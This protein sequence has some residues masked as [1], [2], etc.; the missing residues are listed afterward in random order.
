MP[1]ILAVIYNDACGLEKAAAVKNSGGKKQCVPK[2]AFSLN[3]AKESF[4]F[5]TVTDARTKAAWDAAKLNKDI[6]PLYKIEEYTAA[7]TE[8]KK[9]EGRFDDYITDEAIKGTTY[10]HII[11]DCSYEVIKSLRN[12]GYTR[13]F[14]TLSDGTFTAQ[15]LEDGRIK[16]QPISNYEV[17]ILNDSEIA[18]KPQNADITLKF[19]DHVKSILNPDFDLRTY[20]G[21]YDV[22][23]TEVSA[24]ATAIRFTAASGCSGSL[25]EAFEDGDFVVHDLAGAVQT[26]TFVPPTPQG[27]YELVGTTF[28]TGFTV[29]LDGVVDKVEKAYETVKPLSITV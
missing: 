27:V 25:I 19:E 5:P 16:G 20:E 14:I 24:S 26:V 6:I 7:N 15:A 13:V 3:M 29:S 18:G 22:E 12:A 11:G 28:T 2:P 17:G 21:V 10:N 1:L 8:E 23:L 4:S 9:Y